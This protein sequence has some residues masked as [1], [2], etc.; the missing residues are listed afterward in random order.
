M[1]AQRQRSGGFL[2]V[3]AKPGMPGLQAT[4]SM[5]SENLLKDGAHEPSEFG[6]RSRKERQVGDRNDMARKGIATYHK[7]EPSHVLW[8]VLRSAA[9]GSRQKWPGVHRGIESSP[10][11]SGQ[12]K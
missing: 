6:G 1:I 9:L 5:A 7:P 8:G 11:A 3:S 4:S 2:S 12:A 10:P